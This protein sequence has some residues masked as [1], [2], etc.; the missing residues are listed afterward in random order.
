[1]ISYQYVH[2][3]VNE[4]WVHKIKN[5]MNPLILGPSRDAS[6]MNLMIFIH[7]LWTQNVSVFLFRS[8]VQL[9]K[10]RMLK[11]NLFYLYETA[12]LSQ[13]CKNFLERGL[14]SKI[15]VEAIIRIFDHFEQGSCGTGHE[16]SS[17]RVRPHTSKFWTISSNFINP[18]SHP[19]LTDDTNVSVPFLSVAFF[20]S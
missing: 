14:S 6:H 17:V 15:L 1:M 13:Q 4:S 12:L 8:D 11:V 3:F 20:V 19:V 16:G 10:N 9:I 7:I 2:H 5:Q 18:P